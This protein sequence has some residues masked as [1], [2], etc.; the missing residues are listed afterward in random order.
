MYIWIGFGLVIC[1]A[2]GGRV[3]G[4]SLHSIKEWRCGTNQYRKSIT[5]FRVWGF[6]GLQL[7]A[8]RVAGFKF[9]A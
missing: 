7:R 8:Y 3:Y 1:V 5:G 6:L 4:S 2:F 9:T